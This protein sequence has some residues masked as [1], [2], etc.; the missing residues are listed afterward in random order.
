M[1]ALQPAISDG[2]WQKE[3]ACAL[4]LAER[5]G[6]QALFMQGKTEKRLKADGSAVSDAD[7]QC[8]ALIHSIIRATFPMTPLS[9]KKLAPMPIV[10]AKTEYG[11]SIRLTVPMLIS[12]ALTTG[13]CIS[14][15]P[16]VVNWFSVPSLFPVII[17]FSSVDPGHGAECYVGHD[18]HHEIRAHMRKQNVLV[19]SR[20]NQ[21][22]N[23]FIRETLSEFTHIMGSSVGV[24]A[25]QLISEQADLYAYLKPIWEWD[26]CC[27]ACGA[28]RSRWCWH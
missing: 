18:L 6:A 8:D 10:V 2:P 13:P 26:L 3:Y 28:T 12:M 25:D 11:S 4:T 23:Q 14:V 9:A 24:K 16:Y 19:T 21:G 7:E 17:A 1:P 20:R 15:L 5:A 27:A 22:H